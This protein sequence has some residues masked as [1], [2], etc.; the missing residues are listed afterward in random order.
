MGTPRRLIRKK[1]STMRPMLCILV[2]LP[3]VLSAR[4]EE[5]FVFGTFTTEHLVQILRDAFGADFLN[6][7]THTA[8]TAGCPAALTAAGL[9]FATAGCSAACSLLESQLG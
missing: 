9:G 5:R 4:I 1:A 2:L 6:N 3:F 7:F 8:C